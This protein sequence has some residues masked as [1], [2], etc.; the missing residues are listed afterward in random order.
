MEVRGSDRKTK[1]PPSAGLFYGSDSAWRTYSWRPSISPH[2]LTCRQFW[3]KQGSCHMM[4]T[5]H[6]SIVGLSLAMCACVSQPVAPTSY[7]EIY[8]S[9]VQGHM[10]MLRTHAPWMTEAETQAHAQAQAA[11]VIKSLKAQKQLGEV[12][13]PIMI[14]LPPPPRQMRLVLWRHPHSLSKVLRLS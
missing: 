13:P 9:Y 4:S 5:T 3:A 8:N 6:A 14:P 11:E 1:A 7:D 10:E 12:V 2:P